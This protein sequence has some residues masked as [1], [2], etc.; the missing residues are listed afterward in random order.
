MAYTLRNPSCAECPHNLYFMEPAPRK[1]HGVMM[2]CGERFCTGGKRTRRFKRS[3]PKIAV[4]SWCPKRKSPCELRVYALKSRQDWLLHVSLADDPNHP[5]YV[6]ERRYAL[7]V[8]TE[9]AMTPKEFWD[10]SQA[11]PCTDLFDFEVPLYAV[12]EIDDGLAPAFFYWTSEGF[13][14]IP[15]FN[16]GRTK[17]NRREESV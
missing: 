16:A 17:A 8:H 14:I 15:H 3:D 13:K 5:L 9:T 2:H 11:E 4:P 6:S 7:A 1:Q 12:V 10:R